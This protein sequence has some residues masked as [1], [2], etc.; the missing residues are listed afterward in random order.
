LQLTST[1][2]SPDGAIPA[3]YTCDGTDASPPLSWSDPPEGTE[4]FVVLCTDPDARSFT[5]WILFNL[6]PGTRHLAPGLS[7]QAE[8][9]DGS[10]QGRNS[11]GKL[12]YRGPCPPRG[13]H[14]YIFR[15]YALNTK[16]D[17]EA[18]VGRRKVEQA[19]LDHLVAQ[20]ELV[21]EYTRAAR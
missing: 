1:A 3:Y 4:S 6:P 9:A 14:R 13:T 19:I 11:F 15:L 18:G 12:G 17:L 10:R 2:F 20:G 5:H 8:L 21:G 16:L 7:P